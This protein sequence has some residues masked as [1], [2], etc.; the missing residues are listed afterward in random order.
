M[1]QSIRIFCCYAREDQPFLLELKDQLSLLEHNGLI[2]V[3]A[4]INVSPGEEW[5]KKISHYLNTAQIILLLVSARFMAS[6]YCYSKEMK[7]AI[8]RHKAGE[9]R[10]IP[11]ILRPVDWKKG[12]P[13][14]KLQALPTDARPITSWSDQHEAFF[15]VA[16]GIRD[17]VEKYM[18]LVHPQEIALF[19][20]ETQGG[21]KSI[22]WNN[23][24]VFSLD[25]LY[26]MYL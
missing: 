21:S 11:V 23:P 2:T 16:K 1:G 13:F 18:I 26:E 22:I 5:E 8:E 6:D 7:R 20:Y 24:D 19:G 14:S 12:A 15:N 25:E 17:I 4:D 10:V 3:Q 9:A